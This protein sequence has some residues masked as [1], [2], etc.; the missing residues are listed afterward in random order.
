[1]TFYGTSAAEGIPSPFCRCRVCENAR[2]VRGKEIRRRSMLRLSD[3]LCID[4]GAD[5]LQLAIEFG[6][7]YDL[8]HVLVTHTH[9]DHFAHMIPYVLALSAQQPPEPLNFYFTDRA[10]RYVDFMRDNSPIIKGLTQTLEQQGV[11]AFHRLEFYQTSKIGG[12]SVLPLKGSHRG[13]VDELSANYLIEMPSGRRLFYG[14]DTGWYLDE[15]FESL[16]NADISVFVGECSHGINP[17]RERH[18]KIHMDAHSNILLLE[19]LLAI[20]AISPDT[21]VYITHISHTSTHEELTAFF[22]DVDLPFKTPITVAYDGLTGP[23]GYGL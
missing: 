19:K 8:R 11:V 7:F 13:N 10:F 21:R 3:T 20:G 22:N 2:T 5:A 15:T 4:M 6:D 23:D 17:D 16:E 12:M 18:P 9:E 1:M 14:L